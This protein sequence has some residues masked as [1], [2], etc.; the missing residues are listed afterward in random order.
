M[1]HTQVIVRP[2]EARDA[3][4]IDEFFRRVRRRYLT[5]G[6]EDWPSILRRG[7]VFVAQTG[8]LLWGVLAVVPKYRGWGEIRALGLIDG[9]HARTG[10]EMLYYKA[11]PT[12]VEMGIT[13]L[14]IV[15]SEGWL[16]GP[17]DGLGFVTRERVATYLRHAHSVPPI[18]ATPADIRLV[19]LD[20]I[21]QVA[22]LDR[23]AF[24][25]RWVYTEREL[26][27]MLVTGSRL[28]AAFVEDTLVGYAS[29][30]ILDDVGHIS[31]LAV[32][33]RWQGQGIGRQ[34]LLEGMHYLQRAGVS[35]MSLNTQVE[36]TRAVRLYESLHF[37]RF[38]RL[39]PVLERELEGLR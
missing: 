6:G 26:A 34:L 10:V 19:R 27:H 13:G 36:N 16:Q 23:M 39:I 33:P 5:F 28:T 15:L 32:H 7:H 20:Q 22:R 21:A 35:R 29:V 24:A 1:R 8:P 38:G 18:P 2:A 3:Q 25:P 9:W 31:R 30:Q 12:L 17:L 37:R 4:D 11:H 14:Y